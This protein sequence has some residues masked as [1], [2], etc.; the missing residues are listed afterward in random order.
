MQGKY[1]SFRIPQALRLVL[2]VRVLGTRKLFCKS[3]YCVSFLC[4]RH[5]QNLSLQ[6]QRD[7]GGFPKEAAASHGQKHVSERSQAIQ[8]NCLGRGQEV[9]GLGFVSS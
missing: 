9:N 8:K 2:K 3:P 4:A 5:I 1:N 7:V 6:T